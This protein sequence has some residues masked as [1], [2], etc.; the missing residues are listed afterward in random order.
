M[1]VNNNENVILIGYFT[2]LQAEHFALF[3]ELQQVYHFNIFLNLIPKNHFA[4]DET[5]RIFDQ[6][7]TISK[8][9]QNCQINKSFLVK[10]QISA[11]ITFQSDL[12]KVNINIP[13]INISDYTR[14]QSPIFLLMDRSHPDYITSSSLFQLRQSPTEF[15]SDPIPP[16]I[17]TA[18]LNAAQR[19]P[20][21]GNLQA[22]TLVLIQTKSLI[23][24]IADIAYKQE[25]IK[26]AAGLFAIVVE[27]ELSGV[28]YGQRGRSF[29]SLE[30]AT[31]A[32]S[33]LQ[34][35]LEAFGISTRWIGA[36]KNDELA[37]AI[38]AQGK[39]IAG[40][41]AFGYPLRYRQKSS[42]RALDQ[43]LTVI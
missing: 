41:I 25:K 30:D 43:Y 28:K 6:V 11:I 22:Y 16:A 35:A 23:H 3:D 18:A 17:I 37:D 12:F 10:H 9:F 14:S 32:G 4:I 33:H 19:S 2:N 7:R 36:Y 29:Y 38:S 20:S 21:A 27:P 24:H 15:S 5:A 40:I 8:V 39:I 34:L 42:R 1:S 26:T 13:T 31:I